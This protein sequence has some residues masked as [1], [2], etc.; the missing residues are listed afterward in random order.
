MQEGNG[1]YRCANGVGISPVLPTHTHNT[2][3]QA[4]QV[5]MIG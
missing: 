4:T 5:A 1:P 2:H 3:T